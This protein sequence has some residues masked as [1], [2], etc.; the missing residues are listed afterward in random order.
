MRTDARWWLALGCLA[1]TAL[2]QRRVPFEFDG[3]LARVPPQTQQKRTALEAA[4]PAWQELPASLQTLDSAPAGVTTPTTQL[5]VFA[6]VKAQFLRAVDAGVAPMVWPAPTLCARSASFTAPTTTL[7]APGASVT[8]QMREAAVRQPL[9]AVTLATC[10][11]QEEPERFVSA[12]RVPAGLSQSALNSFVDQRTNTLEQ[13]LGLAGAGLALVPVRQGVLPPDWVPTMRSVLWKVRG[14]DTARLAATRTAFQNSITILTTDAPC[15][16]SMSGP[17]LRADLQTMV[18]ELNAVE[19]HIAQVIAQ[20][21]AAAA[22]QRQCLVNRGRTRPTLPVPALTDEEREFV[23]FWLGGVYWRMRGA[24]LLQL[25]STQNARTYFARRPFRE[26]ARLA[27]GTAVGERAADALYCGLFDGWG[28]WMDMGTSMN[29]SGPAEDNQ[30]MYDDLV[31]MTNRGREQVAA[32]TLATSPCFLL[33]VSGNKHAE[34]QL[35]DS[36]YDTQA[37]FA[38]GLQMGPCYLYSLNPL[39][40]FNWYTTAQAQAPYSGFLE[41]FTALGEFCT[42]AALGLG[43]TKSL[44]NGTPTG[45]P[46]TNACGTRQ[47]GVDACGVSCGACVGGLACDAAGQC[48]NGAGGGTAGGSAGGASGGAATAG[49]SA[50]GSSGGS[51]AAGGTAGGSSG[52]SSTAGGSATQEGAMPSTG[53]GCSSGAVNGLLLPGLLFLCRRRAPRVRTKP[54]APR[55]IAVHVSCRGDGVAERRRLVRLG[56]PGGGGHGQEELEEARSGRRRARGTGAHRSSRAD[57][58]LAWPAA[59]LEVTH[60]TRRGRP[61]HHRHRP[62]RNRDANHGA[63]FVAQQL[64]ADLERPTS[65]RR[66]HR[67]VRPLPFRGV[68]FGGVGAEVQVEL[69]EATAPSA[70]RLS[71]RDAVAALDHPDR[72]KDRRTAPQQNE[73]QREHDASKQRANGH[74]HLHRTAPGE[75]FQ[76]WNPAH[77]PALNVSPRN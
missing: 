45:Q 42:G 68:S 76:T 77:S 70:I 64:P 16:H 63:V 40:N 75:W 36:N 7:L 74:G 57:P 34:E 38:G 11:D 4:L 25:G 2:A 44:L 60:R 32:K 47:C 62:H 35:R 52:G 21:T 69:H 59:E 9:T 30:D 37:L 66:G 6:E 43:L 29:P 61:G 8:C 23:A 46:P 50:G 56:C 31:G 14:A 54:D 55:G 13:Q 20:G 39:Q 67:G 12:S 65:A 28:S 53:C 10:V 19:A 48:V 17:Q 33:N 71:V 58:R 22:Q 51:A 18:A 3:G 27:N 15:F 73:T 49:G 24:G 1:T 72:R 41:G 5:W 26:I